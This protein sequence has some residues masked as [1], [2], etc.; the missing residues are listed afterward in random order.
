MA[1]F[2]YVLIFF[3]ICLYTYIKYFFLSRDVYSVSTWHPSSIP[4]IFNELSNEIT[5]HIKQ[6]QEVENNLKLFLK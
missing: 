3:N 2:I 5:Q 1:K 4:E 6:A